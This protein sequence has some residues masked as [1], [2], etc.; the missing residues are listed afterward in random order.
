M[1]LMGQH[2]CWDQVLEWWALALVLELALWELVLVPGSGLWEMASEL[3]AVAWAKQED[4]WAGQSPGN[5]AR[6]VAPQLQSIMC[7]KMVGQSPWSPAGEECEL[8]LEFYYIWTGDM[9]NF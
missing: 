3:L 9:V 1:H 4:S 2:H 5:P 6:E 7:K 8:G